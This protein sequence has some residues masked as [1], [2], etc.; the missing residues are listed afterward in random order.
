ML[1]ALAT[2]ANRE[3]PRESGRDMIDM[4]EWLL[5]GRFHVRII[6]VSRQQTNQSRLTVNPLQP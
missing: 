3:I 6:G 2:F 4:G 1:A 5:P